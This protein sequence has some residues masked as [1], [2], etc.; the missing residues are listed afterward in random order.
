MENLTGGNSGTGLTI[1]ERLSMSFSAVFATAL[2]FH[3]IFTGV[4]MLA[5]VSVFTIPNSKVQ[6]DLLL[7]GAGQSD[8]NELFTSHFLKSL[9]EGYQACKLGRIDLVL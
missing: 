3:T 2:S 1:P 9:K 4:E 5:V 6:A 8:I 7:I